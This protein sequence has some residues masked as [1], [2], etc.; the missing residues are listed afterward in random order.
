MAHLV[1]GYNAEASSNAVDGD[2][3]PVPHFGAALSVAQFQGLAARLRQAGVA[4]DIEPHLRFAG[5]PGEQVRR[6]GRGGVQQG[7]GGGR[8]RCMRVA[9]W[10]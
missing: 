1:K 8:G 10:C 4:F 3:V 9:C 6:E 2:A 5:Q 7:G